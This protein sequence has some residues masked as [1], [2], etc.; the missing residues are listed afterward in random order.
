MTTLE[1][2][3][4]GQVP[5]QIITSALPFDS[6]YREQVQELHGI[7][8]AGYEHITPATRFSLRRYAGPAFVSKPPSL[9]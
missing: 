6:W 5:G 2:Q 4:V 9:T 8:L 1:A 3:D 7:N